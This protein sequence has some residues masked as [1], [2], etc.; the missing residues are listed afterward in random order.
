[1]GHGALKVLNALDRSQRRLGEV[2][3]AHHKAVELL[4]VLTFLLRVDANLPLPRDLRDARH[5]R[6]QAHELVHFVVLG[7]VLQVR[8]HVRVR[9]EAG[10]PVLERELLELHDGGRQVR[11]QRLERHHIVPISLLPLPQ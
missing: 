3:V 5:R 7:V 11:V 9:G 6:V 8:Q 1:V 10:H 4:V 2:T